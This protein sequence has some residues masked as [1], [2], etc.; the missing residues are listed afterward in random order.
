MNIGDHS[1]V[2]GGERFEL[3]KELWRFKHESPLPNGRSASQNFVEPSGTLMVR[4]YGCESSLP[5]P[6]PRLLSESAQSGQSII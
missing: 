5:S 4:R 3:P 6:S 2:Q 1:Q